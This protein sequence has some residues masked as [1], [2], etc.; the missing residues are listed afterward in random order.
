VAYQ[1]KRTLIAQ[2]IPDDR[3][4][5]PVTGL[6][7]PMRWR[8]WQ[9]GGHGMIGT[10]GDYARFLQM[11]LNGGSFGGKRYLKPET[12]ALMTSDRIGP[13]TKIVR[14]A[15]YYPGPDSGFGLGFA[16]RTVTPPH[17]KL[18]TGEYRWDGA[19]GT[20][21]FVDPR[22]DMFVICMM[23]TLSQ[24][25]RIETEVKALVYDAVVEP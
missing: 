19:G 13:E 1:V 7:D 8:R 20:F 24:R 3:S 11:L 17:T 25:A 9:A 21:F 12:V 23:Q 22:H 18:P 14:D 4:N 15:Y 16:V 2:P 10:I 5:G 6:S